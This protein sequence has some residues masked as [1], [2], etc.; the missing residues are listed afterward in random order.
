MTTYQ[1]TAPDG[2]KYKITAPEGATEEQ[3]LEHFKANWQAPQAEV[4]QAE[5]PQAPE[6]SLD[7][8]S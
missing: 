5:V 4:P 7:R 3:A 2:A 1:V 8:R 6:S